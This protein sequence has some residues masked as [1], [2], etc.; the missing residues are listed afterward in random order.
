M[1]EQFGEH[2]RKSGADRGFSVENTFLLWTRCPMP[3]S[4][5][6]SEARE[7]AHALENC[8]SRSWTLTADPVSQRASSSRALS[9]QVLILKWVASQTCTGK[10]R[11]E[12]STGE[13]LRLGVR[14]GQT[15]G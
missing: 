1:S 13:R 14:D 7:V 5:L 2:S 10:P 4:A 15:A 6:L 9:E 8:L 12:R 3:Y 11:G